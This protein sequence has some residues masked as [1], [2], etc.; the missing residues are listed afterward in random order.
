MIRI[1]EALSTCPVIA[2]LRGVEPERAEVIG[3][4]L[5]DVGVRVIEVP[6]NSPEPFKSIS[7]LARL[8]EKRAV[9]GAGTVLTDEDV[10]TVAAAGGRL[11]VS[12]NT[13]S[14]VIE[15]TKRCGLVSMPGFFTPTEA[16]RALASGLVK[17]QQTLLPRGARAAMARLVSMRHSNLYVVALM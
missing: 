8:F 16:F 9:I 13:N 6:L 14:G 15:E 7:G 4:A 10:R 12:P 3:Q 2:I 17:T 1:E 5:F 11:V